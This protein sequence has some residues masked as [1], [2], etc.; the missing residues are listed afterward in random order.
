MHKWQEWYHKKRK[1]VCELNS[2]FKE[3]DCVTR[4][5]Y[6]YIIVVAFLAAVIW[7]LLRG[8]SSA[9]AVVAL[10]GRPALVAPIGAEV[11]GAVRPASSGR[12]KSDSTSWTAS[13]TTK[14]VWKIF[15]SDFHIFCYLSQSK[16]WPKVCQWKISQPLELQLRRLFLAYL[17]ERHWLHSAKIPHSFATLGLACAISRKEIH[18][19]LA[20]MKNCALFLHHWQPTFAKTSRAM[21]FMGSQVVRHVWIYGTT[22]CGMVAHVQILEALHCQNSMVFPTLWKGKNEN[23]T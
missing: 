20:L 11:G 4:N 9:V 18:R 5:F 22:E 21:R 14:P 17:H 13:W 10:A 2:S 19:L 12:G 8:D 15:S 6:P 7:V 23:Q 3:C 1:I 16:N